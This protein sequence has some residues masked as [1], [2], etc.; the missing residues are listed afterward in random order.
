M[1]NPCQ[2]MH[3]AAAAAGLASHWLS[4]ERDLEQR[5]KA[6]LGVPEVLE[7]HS[8]VVLGYPAFEPP[9]PYRRELKEIVHY[10]KYDKSKYRTGQDIINYLLTLRATLRVQLKAVTELEPWDD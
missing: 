6:I 9:T 2:T 8:L 4:I 1:A 3:L 10:E 7:I 5:F